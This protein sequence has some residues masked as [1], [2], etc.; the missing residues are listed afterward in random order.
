MQLHQP[1]DE[2]KTDA[3]PSLLLAARALREKIEDVRKNVSAV[4]VP[5]PLEWKNSLQC[6]ATK[7]CKPLAQSFAS[8]WSACWQSI[9]RPAPTATI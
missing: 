3:E 9:R 6:V 1:L 7:R 4:V 5:L 8:D 2:R